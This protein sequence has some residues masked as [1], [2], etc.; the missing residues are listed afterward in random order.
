MKEMSHTSRW[1]LK[2]IAARALIVMQQDS[3]VDEVSHT[4]SDILAAFARVY[5]Q[6]TFLGLSRPLD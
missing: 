2:L 3:V 5:A 6:M 1:L 4:V